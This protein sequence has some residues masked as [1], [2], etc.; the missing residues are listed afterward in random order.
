MQPAIGI[1]GDAVPAVLAHVSLR[2]R[3][4]AFQVQAGGK[5]HM[6]KINR[7]RLRTG[8]VISFSTGSRPVIPIA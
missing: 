5:E 2:A 7:A 6:L 8:C 4:R 3:P 1:D